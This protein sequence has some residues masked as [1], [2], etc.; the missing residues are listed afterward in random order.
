MMLGQ[1]HLS[2][3][4]RSMSPTVSGDEFSSG[5][6]W[7]FVDLLEKIASTCEMAKLDTEAEVKELCEGVRERLVHAISLGVSHLERS[8][9]RVDSSVLNEFKY[10]ASAL[11]DEVLVN[12]EWRGKDRWIDF[13]LEDYF[14]GSTIAGDKVFQNID[15]ILASR[16]DNQKIL[17][18][19]YLGL[20]AIGFEGKYRGMEDSG[21]LAQFKQELFQSLYGRTAALSVPGRK[22]SDQPYLHTARRVVQSRENIS[23]WP[24]WFAASSVV[25][26]AVAGSVAW[27]LTIEPLPRLIFQLLQYRI[28]L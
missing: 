28:G 19:L 1:N 11:A 22:V 26:V 20:L 8:L 10:V 2:V 9:L 15:K 21:I 18:F 23:N 14:C 3:E 13:L 12:L 17:A 24:Y 4:S 5:A 25:V 16:D 7:V 6:E 27:N